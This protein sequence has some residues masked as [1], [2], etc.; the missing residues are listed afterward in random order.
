MPADPVEQVWGCGPLKHHPPSLSAW[1]EPAVSAQHPGSD[2][3]SP[4]SKFLC[5]NF[6]FSFFPLHF[7]STT[8]TIAVQ[9][10]E[11]CT[12]FRRGHSRQ[13]WRDNPGQLISQS[14]HCALL[15]GGSGIGGL[16]GQQGT[17]PGAAEQVLAD[18]VHRAA[19]PV[20]WLRGGSRARR[21]FRTSD[22]SMS[23]V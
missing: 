20:E 14:V 7:Q 10:R 4:R 15:A 13:A 2:S 19:K 12:H 5:L 22:P 21:C 9:A 3:L 18:R 16:T 17:H 6:S 11:Y 1:H 8:E 23:L